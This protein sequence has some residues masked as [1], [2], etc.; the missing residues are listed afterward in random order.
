MTTIKTKLSTIL[1][2][3]ILLSVTSVYA[4]FA[5]IPHNITSGGKVQWIDYDCDGDLDLQLVY[6]KNRVE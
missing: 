6:Q 3:L 2:S 4:Q 1:I 5:E